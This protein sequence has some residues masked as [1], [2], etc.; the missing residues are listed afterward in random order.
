MLA[1]E[2]SKAE[3]LESNTTRLANWKVTT[4]YGLFKQDRIKEFA[5]R[6]NKTINVEKHLRK[7]QVY[8]NM[9]EDQLLS[10]FSDYQTK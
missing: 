10:I 6:A 9:N 7:L 5:N 8:K 3:A 4:S 1:D 2:E